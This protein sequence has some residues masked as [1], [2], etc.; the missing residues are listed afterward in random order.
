M[1]ISLWPSLH[2]MHQSQNNTC[3]HVLGLL[4]PAF[5]TRV[6]TVFFKLLDVCS[7][8]NISFPGYFFFPAIIWRI[9]LPPFLS[10][11][12]HSL[13]SAL[14]PPTVRSC[15]SVLMNVA[16]S[17]RTVILF[18]AA[19]AELVLALLCVAWDR[20][21]LSHYLLLA[22][23]NRCINLQPDVLWGLQ[24]LLLHPDGWKSET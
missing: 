4:S 9:Q 24:C 15:S 14:A 8:R 13:F 21:V 20:S 23:A 6:I 1:C 5:C 10:P 19:D 3:V 22:S 16:W 17:H 7:T 2:G 18:I 12:S 11:L